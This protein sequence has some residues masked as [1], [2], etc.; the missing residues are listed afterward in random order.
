M[1]ALADGFRAMA[2]VAE[3]VARPWPSPHPA[4]AIAIASPENAATQFV[5]A[6][7]PP[8][9][10]AGTAKHNADRT[11]STLLKMRICFLSYELP[12][13]GGW[14]YRADALTLKRL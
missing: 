4:A 12:P 2:S 6:A 5:G 8:S 7:A 3:A 14:R 11:I 9:A 10:N 1:A 13:V